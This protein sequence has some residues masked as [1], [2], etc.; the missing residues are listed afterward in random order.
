MNTYP[1]FY[2]PLTGRIGSYWLDGTQV[3]YKE[4]ELI[5]HSSANSAYTN[6]ERTVTTKVL[7][8]PSPELVLELVAREANRK[9][10]SQ[11]FSCLPG[12]KLRNFN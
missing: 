3:K 11:E 7:C 6:Y 1:F 5:D 2:E 10:L 9:Q 8:N 12:Y 4:A